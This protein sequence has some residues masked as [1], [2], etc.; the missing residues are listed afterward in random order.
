MEKRPGNGIYLTWWSYSHGPHGQSLVSIIMRSQ[1]APYPFLLFLGPKLEIET[2]AWRQGSTL[3][4][5]WA[6]LQNIVSH[7]MPEATQ[8]KRLKQT[9]F[10]FARTIETNWNRIDCTN[11]RAGG[12][13]NYFA[14]QDAQ[15]TLRI[16]TNE[17]REQSTE[18]RKKNRHC[19]KTWKTAGLDD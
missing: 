18:L 19:K 11:L 12:K 8:P 17:M 4:H 3:D 14:A 9:V 13:A 5:G 16:F 2:K 15:L 7:V 10:E 6:R 1:R